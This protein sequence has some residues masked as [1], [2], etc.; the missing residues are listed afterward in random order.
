MKLN[1]KTGKIVDVAVVDESDKVITITTHGIVMKCP[2]KEIRCC[3]RSTQ[4]VKLINLVDWD[5]VASIARIPK[6]DKPEEEQGD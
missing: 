4:G 3:G 2:V 5:R 6:T 1:Q